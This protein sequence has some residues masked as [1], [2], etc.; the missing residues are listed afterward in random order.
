MRRCAFWESQNH[1][2]I[3]NPLFAKKMPLLYLISTGLRNFH[4]ILSVLIYWVWISEFLRWI[5][6]GEISVVLCLSALARG[7]VCECYLWPQSMCAVC[8]CWLN[9]CRVQSSV[10]HW[11]LS[12]H[13]NRMRMRPKLVPN[14]KFDPHLEASR[15]RDN[16]GDWMLCGRVLQLI[17][18]VNSLWKIQYFGML[19]ITVFDILNADHA[20]ILLDT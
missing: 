19:I 17:K 9:A 14:Y 3:L 4:G 1:F 8:V 13:E 7:S 16:E 11:K 20:W 5:F 18:S 2:N 12:P 15:L 6:D 10:V